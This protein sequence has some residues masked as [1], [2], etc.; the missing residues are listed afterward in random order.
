M[1]TFSQSSY[2]VA[3]KETTYQPLHTYM[4]SEKPELLLHLHSH[5]CCNG[6]LVVKKKKKKDGVRKEGMY[7]EHPSSMLKIEELKNVHTF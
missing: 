6:Y 2:K 5:Q 4:S 7:L 3:T 1:Q